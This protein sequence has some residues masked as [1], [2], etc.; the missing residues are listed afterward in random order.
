MFM[1]FRLFLFCQRLARAAGSSVTF[2]GASGKR[3]EPRGLWLA[4]FAVI[5]P[6][7]SLAQADGPRVAISRPGQ[8]DFV[9]RSSEREFVYEHACAEALDKVDV[10][11][12]IGKC[13]DWQDQQYRFGGRTTL[14]SVYLGLQEYA[15]PRFHAFGRGRFVL[16]L[17]CNHGAYNQSSV[18][19]GYDESRLPPSVHPILFPQPDGS[20]HAEIGSR[21]VFARRGRVVEYRKARGMG[22]AGWYALYA[23]RRDTLQATLLEAIAKEEWDGRDRFDWTGHLGDK[24][25][26]KTWKRIYPARK[27]SGGPGQLHGLATSAPE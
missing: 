13:S 21:A 11:D 18:F 20:R 25:R 8:C 15:P 12:L 24:P 9:A 3:L 7:A 16:E 1:S 10:A 17:P 27:T 4:C 23:I 2:T 5:L 6:W 22:D 19:F 26:G 14:L